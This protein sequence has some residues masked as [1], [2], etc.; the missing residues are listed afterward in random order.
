MP[1]E[2]KI[3]LPGLQGG[4]KKEGGATRNLVLAHR[5]AAFIT[6]C[7]LYLAMTPPAPRILPWPHRR[8]LITPAVNFGQGEGE[9]W[10]HVT[11][12]ELFENLPESSQSHHASKCEPADE[13][14]GNLGKHVHG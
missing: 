13:G 14:E 6:N 3:T 7:M 10:H 12:R 8:R 1:Q 4:Y 5:Q 2:S 9:Q 11:K